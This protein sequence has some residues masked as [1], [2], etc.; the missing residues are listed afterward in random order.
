[1]IDKIYEVVSDKTLSFWCI[2]TSK[3]NP[4]KRQ[5]RIAY[6]WTDASWDWIWKLESWSNIADWAIQIIWHPIMIG[7]VLDYLQ[8]NNLLSECI[9]LLWIWN[10]KT[11]P[12]EKQSEECIKFVYDLITKQ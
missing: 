9:D 1:M 10:N 8:S 3:W 11:K 4:N 6:Y 7:C 5:K 12:I 2:V